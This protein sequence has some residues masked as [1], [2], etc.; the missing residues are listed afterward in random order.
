MPTASVY[1]CY[2]RNDNVYKKSLGNNN[3]KKSGEVEQEGKSAWMKFYLFFWLYV[4][5]WNL[6][7]HRMQEKERDRGL[8]LCVPM[9]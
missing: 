4:I 7:A 6:Q 9:Q 1:L 8:D 5:I 3:K 2:P